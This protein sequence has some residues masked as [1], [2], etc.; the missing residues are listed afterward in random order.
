[1]MVYNVYVFYRTIIYRIESDLM[2]SRQSPINKPRTDF[3]A[4]GQARF[5]TKYATANFF[6]AILNESN[7]SGLNL[8]GIDFA[9]AKFNKALLTRTDLYACNLTGAYLANANLVGANLATANLNRAVLNNANLTGASLVGANLKN[10]EFNENTRFPSIERFMDAINMST[11]LRTRLEREAQNGHPPTE[12]PQYTNFNRGYFTKVNLSGTVISR[13]KFRLSVFLGANMSSVTAVGTD[14]SDAVLASANFN[15]ANLRGANLRGADLTG[16]NLQDAILINADLTGAILNGTN[17]TRT[18]LYSAILDDVDLSEAILGGTEFSDADTD[19]A[20]TIQYNNR[21]IF[22]MMA[23]IDLNT[24]FSFS[25]ELEEFIIN[26]NRGDQTPQAEP[27]DRLEY[28]MAIH[29]LYRKID[30][31]AYQNAL[32]NV[33]NKRYIELN[34]DDR[35][36]EPKD[37]K[38]MIERI[39]DEYYDARVDDPRNA[40]EKLERIMNKFKLSAYSHNK[41]TLRS[42]TNSLTYMSIQSPE[43]K[44][45]YV[46]TFIKD[47]SEAYN[48]V[49]NP[50][51]QMSCVDGIIERFIM[52][53]GYTAR[54]LCLDEMAMSDICKKDEYNAIIVALHLKKPDLN[55]LIQEWN[56]VF[57]ETDVAQQMSTPQIRA[58]FVAF[59]REHLEPSGFSETQI[60]K[61]VEEKAEELKT[62]FERKSFGGWRTPIRSRSRRNRRTGTASRRKKTPER[63]PKGRAT[64]RRRRAR[65][66]L[67]APSITLPPHQYGSP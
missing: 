21:T 34:E 15:G 29:N 18:I 54:D 49:A 11:A 4:E 64:A 40:K 30:K 35:I 19:Y 57:L 60:N 67:W 20:R 53:I 52:T 46:Q 33:L 13:K 23:D 9:R 27:Q 37:I 39:I 32:R 22:P 16:A 42:I 66:A 50:E 24:Q 44:K 5:D 45:L 6:D 59:M 36:L 61:I 58:N 51:L 56:E 65:G 55:M 26:Q 63:G 12:L 2:S 38:K 48:D 62:I 17:L 28:Q 10:I 43:F 7:F 31:D 25:P 47:C 8:A 41:E 14:F 3:A 1:M